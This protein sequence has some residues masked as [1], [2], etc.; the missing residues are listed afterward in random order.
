MSSRRDY[1]GYLKAQKGIFVILAEEYE[2]SRRTISGI[3]DTVK[4][5]VVQGDAVNVCRKYHGRKRIEF[6]LSQVS[7]IPLHKRTTIRSLAAATSISKSSVHRL[8]QSGNIRRHTN[9]IKPFLSDANKLQRLKFCL[10]QIEKSVPQKPTFQTFQNVIHI[11]EKWFFMTKISQRLYMRLEDADPHR[12]CKSKRFITK[13]MSLGT[14]GR[15]LFSESG[16]VIWDGKIGMF[17]FVEQ[18]TAKRRSKNRNAGVMETKPI[19]SIT[20]KV[21]KD[22]LINTVLPAIKEK[23]PSQLSKEIIIQQDNARP[24]ISHDD[25]EYVSASMADGFTIT[26]TNQPPNSPDLNIL[27]LGFFRAIQSLKDQNAPKTVDELLHAVDDAFKQLSPLT[28]NKV[29]LS[30]R[31]VMIEVLK[32]QGGNNYKLPHNAKDRMQSEG[33]LPKTIEVDVQLLEATEQI[34][35][36]QTGDT[37]SQGNFIIEEDDDDHHLQ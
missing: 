14:V 35:G 21:F 7:Q 20:K 26:L 11:D 24:H 37:E 8:V 23:W 25:A 15:P 34:L 2:V 29:W 19:L 18:V 32:V 33:I 5:Q 31:Y 36:Q 17:P 30:Y 1:L 16:E 13:V 22:M 6:D 28:L 10:S 27:D 12:V 4:K 3:W 9:A